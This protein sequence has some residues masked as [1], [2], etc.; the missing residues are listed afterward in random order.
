[1]PKAAVDVNRGSLSPQSVGTAILIAF[2][3][4]LV[5]TTTDVA[6]AAAVILAPQ[7]IGAFAPFASRAIGAAPIPRVDGEGG[8]ASPIF[9]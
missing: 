1:M 3:R 8:F 9:W 4:I 7:T 2:A 5:V 6:A